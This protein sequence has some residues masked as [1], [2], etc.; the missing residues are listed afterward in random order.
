MADR[1]GVLAVEPAVSATHPIGTRVLAGGLLAL[2]IS[3]VGLLWLPWVSA[4]EGLSLN[5]RETQDLLN[6][7][8][9]V[10]P[11]FRLT[12]RWTDLYFADHVALVSLAICLVLLLS[13]VALPTRR[14]VI[15]PACAI[16]AVASCA[17]TVLSLTTTDIGVADTGPGMWITASGYLGLAIAVT[18]PVPKRSQS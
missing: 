8:D 13:S 6:L 17:L 4:D 18:W 3:A 12:S 5:F 10:V 1:P 14:R 11:G 15:R 2:V 16:A 7:A 9:S